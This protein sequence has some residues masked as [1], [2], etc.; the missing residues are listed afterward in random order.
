MELVLLG[1]S[2]LTSTVLRRHGIKT[3]EK[4]KAR[5]A[6]AE[7]SEGLKSIKGIGPKRWEEIKN[8]VEKLRGF[9][10]CSECRQALSF[11]PWNTKGD[12]LICDNVS[13]VKFHTVQ[14]WIPCPR[15]S[16]DEVVSGNFRVYPLSSLIST[17]VGS[18][19]L[20]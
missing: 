12:I 18:F 14:G 3:L 15:L 17:E 7:D 8:F 6:M 20:E 9:F 1:L 11:L 2:F 10:Q 4:L 13:C 19:K 5:M 16:M